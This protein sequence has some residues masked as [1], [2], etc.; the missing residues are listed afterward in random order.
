MEPGNR[1]FESHL[2]DHFLSCARNTVIDR[3][4][5]FEKVP[6]HIPHVR[7][8]AFSV[9]HVVF[10]RMR[11]T[12]AAQHFFRE[13]EKSGCS[14]LPRTEEIKGS[15]PLFPTILCLTSESS[16]SR[17]FISAGDGIARHAGL[18]NQCPDKAWE[19]KSPPAD[20][21]SMYGGTGRHS[22]FKTRR[23]RP[24]RSDPCYIDHFICWDVFQSA[25]SRA[26]NAIIVVRVHAPQ[27]IF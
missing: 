27:P 13:L 1:E 14:R 20:Q 18:R 4:Q 21:F 5:G 8:S 10:G 6:K 9:G 17:M 26:L 22:G 19:L 24:C 3:L 23:R 25:G 11:E 12:R 16:C 7:Y 15:N 2:P